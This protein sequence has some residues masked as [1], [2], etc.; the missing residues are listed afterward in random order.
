MLM[1][2]KDSDDFVSIIKV[3]FSVVMVISVGMIIGRIWWNMMCLCDVFIILVVCMNI[4][5]WI[6]SVLVWVVCR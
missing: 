2:R 4:C 1:L 5:L 3:K 6:F